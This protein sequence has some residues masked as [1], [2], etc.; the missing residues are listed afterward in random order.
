M[1]NFNDDI[2]EQN[3]SMGIT[4]EDFADMLRSREKLSADMWDYICDGYEDIL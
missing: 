1:Y 3:D 2:M 4:T